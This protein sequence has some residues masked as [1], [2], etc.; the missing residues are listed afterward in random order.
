MVNVHKKVKLPGS[1]RKSIL[2]NTIGKELPY[3]LLHAPKQG[4]VVPVRE[5]FKDEKFKNRFI[6]LSKDSPFFNN[7]II[8]RIISD[9]K[10]GRF[11]NGN[12]IWMLFV[13]EKFIKE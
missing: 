1:E 13:L 11:D 5:W 9:N 3:S 6:A 12:F 4:F 7:D 2:K 10:T 8:K